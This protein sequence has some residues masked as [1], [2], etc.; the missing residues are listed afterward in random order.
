[1]F[2]STLYHSFAASCS[3]IPASSI[4]STKG[5]ELPSIIG[6]SGPLISIWQLSTPIPTRA[7]S[8][9]STVLTF[10]PLDSNVVP[11]LVSVTKSQSALMVGCAGRS[12]RLNCSPNPGLAGFSVRSATIPVCKPVPEIVAAPF[13]VCCLSGLKFGFIDGLLAGKDNV[14]SQ[15]QGS[16]QRV[17]HM[18]NGQILFHDLF[19]MSKPAISCHSFY[20]HAERLADIVVIKT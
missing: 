19:D 2:S 8:T 9:C 6:I 13:R 18:F 14:S 4:N 7:A 3:K 15:S 17:G 10:P 5:C 20:H 1:M 16:N 11:L 12:M